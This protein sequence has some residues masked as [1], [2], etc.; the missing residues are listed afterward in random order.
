M[1]L[2]RHIGLQDY[3]YACMHLRTYVSVCMYRY[4]QPK[5]VYK[6][7]TTRTAPKME[8][9]NPKIPR[10]K[11]SVKQVAK[12]IFCPLSYLRLPGVRK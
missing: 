11:F 1:Y 8:I 10:H 12:L 2:G 4:V 6:P 5:F 9:K 7:Y 3:T